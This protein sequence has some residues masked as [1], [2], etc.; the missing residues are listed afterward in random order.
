MMIGSNLLLY[1]S[2]ARGEAY[3]KSDVDLL[4]LVEG[5][6]RKVINGVISLSLY[7]YSKMRKMSSCGA[8]FAYHLVEESLVLNDEGGCLMRNIFEVFRKKESYME[9]MCFSRYL[10]SH[11]EARYENLKTYGYANL[12]VGWCM[13][14]F[15]AALGANN[16][17]VMFSNKKI[18]KEFGASVAEYMKVKNSIE[19]SAEIIRKIRLFMDEH[20]FGWEEYSYGNDLIIF[21]EQVLKKMSFDASC[22]IDY[23]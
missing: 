2:L 6:S 11:I 16:N 1:G 20:V 17:E 12:R 19:N 8:L 7:N 14:T 9:E 21:K 4:S 23:V 22:V 13:R 15:V 18:A 10:L 5:N 3:H